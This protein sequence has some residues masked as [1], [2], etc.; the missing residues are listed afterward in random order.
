MQKV[1]LSLARK[2]A[3]LVSVREMHN[4][5]LLVGGGWRKAGL[6]AMV[7]LAWVL[8]DPR[9]CRAEEQDIPL[10]LQSESAP[11]LPV[12]LATPSLDHPYFWEKPP[13]ETPLRKL[14]ETAD[15]AHRDLSAE[16][17]EQA[18][19]LDDYFGKARSDKEQRANYF[20]RWRN[21]L[22]WEKKGGFSYATDVRLA[23]S[24]PK[25]DERLRLV[26]SGENEPE[27]PNPALPQDPGN[28][29]FDRTLQQKTGVVNS[30]L[31]Y[32][33]LR[34]PSTD[35]FLGT[36]IGFVLPPYLF[37]RSRL[38]YTHNFTDTLR[39]RLAETLF[40]KTGVGPGE[41][42]EATLEKTLS[43]KTVLNW[44]TAATI[45]RE[46]APLEWGTE[47]SLLHIFSPR[48]AVTLTEGVYGNVGIDD[49]IRSYRVAFN[50]RRNFLRPWLF[51]ELEPQ[52]AWTYVS[53]SNFPVNY[54]FTARVE[55]TFD[56]NGK[57]VAKNSWE[58]R[59]ARP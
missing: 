9:I 1:R 54:I 24:L 25:I 11:A 47:L 59:L 3:A 39:A 37:A 56:G 23:L 33:L 27:Q 18:I 34:T 5:V 42:S 45:S 28:P 55:V 4:A 36:G 43:P 6:L 12:W 53:D 44:S 2:E 8:T 35:F 49:W 41:T 14:G 29:G 21:G 7:L 30:E 50:F 58:E 10:L 19:W 57:T 15:K 38:Q 20:L 48:T 13:E 26:V 40:V 52:V 22:R 32:S 16:I 46:T 31:R 17:L 51:Y